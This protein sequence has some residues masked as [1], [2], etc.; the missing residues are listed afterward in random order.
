MG[1]AEGIPHDVASKIASCARTKAT[2]K[3]VN[4]IFLMPTY[5]SR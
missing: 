3:A 5:R 4:G 2:T 1:D